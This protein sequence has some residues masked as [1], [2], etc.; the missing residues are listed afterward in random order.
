MAP[1]RKAAA[2]LAPQWY[3]VDPYRTGQVCNGGLGLRHELRVLGC[4]NHC[5]LCLVLLE[6]VVVIRYFFN[7][8][9]A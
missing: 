4:W 6:L 8:A 3:R 7:A 9:H 2:G 1:K 5:C